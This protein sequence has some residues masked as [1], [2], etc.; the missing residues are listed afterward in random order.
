M[1]QRIGISTSV[2]D[3]DGAR[4][5]AVDGETL[6]SAEYGSR[7]VTRTATLDGGSVAY[8]TGFSASDTTLIITP[9]ES[10]K[11]IGDWF[12]YIVQNYSSVNVVTPRRVYYATPSKVEVR[13]SLPILTLMII[14]QIV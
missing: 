7:R 2:F 5:V 9:V 10:E 14:E 12:N 11:D 1:I 13:N 6:A 4:A 8:D 3:A